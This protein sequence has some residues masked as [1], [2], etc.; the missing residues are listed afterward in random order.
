MGTWGPGNFANDTAAD[1]LSLITA[2]LRDDIAAA[3]AGAPDLIE[4]DEWGGATVPCNVEL[5]ALIAEQ[6]WVGTVL[7]DAATVQAWKETYLRTWDGYID[8]LS[9]NPEW[10]QERRAVLVATFDRLLRSCEKK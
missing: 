6:P 7:P 10:K 4:P 8:R 9:P 2:K 3:I 5:L 1:H